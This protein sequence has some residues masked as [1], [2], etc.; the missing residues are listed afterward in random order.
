[1]EGDAAQQCGRGFGSSRRQDG[2]AALDFL[3]GHSLFV[4]V[5]ED[6]GEEVRSVDV[7]PELQ[8]L[9]DSFFVV[10]R[11]LG[12]LFPELSGQD[13]LDRFRE[14]REAAGG[15]E[16]G[17]ELDGL[18]NDTD[19]G[20][21]FLILETMEGLAEREISDDVEGGEVVPLHQIDYSPFRTGDLFL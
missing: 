12:A 18:E 5:S 2:G 9:V 21:I 1:M 4:V 8:P 10:L 17:A 14:G 6:V 3:P 19:P 15:L 11:P 13:E 16:V 7:F 20:V